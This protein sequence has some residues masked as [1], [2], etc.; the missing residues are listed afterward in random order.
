M[1]YFAFLLMYLKVKCREEERVVKK[2]GIGAQV[3]SFCTGN[4]VLV[5]SN[6]HLDKG[7]FLSLLWENKVESSFE[8]R[9]QHQVLPWKEI[10]C[11]QTYEHPHREDLGL[12]PHLLFK[13][14][15]FCSLCA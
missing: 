8:K 13:I 12:I 2:R 7:L 15:T 14:C 6:L 10:I 11:L 3:I 4:Y 1:H 9:K 5:A